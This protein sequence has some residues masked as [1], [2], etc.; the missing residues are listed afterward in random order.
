MGPLQEMQLLGTLEHKVGKAEGAAKE[1]QQQ[2]LIPIVLQREPL[3]E[4]C[5]THSTLQCSQQ[6]SI[7][8]PKQGKK[9]QEGSQGKRFCL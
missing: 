1:K 6:D 8:R 5:S 2:R 4:A 7:S 9:H 3:P